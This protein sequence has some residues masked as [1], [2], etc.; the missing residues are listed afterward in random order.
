VFAQHI[1]RTNTTFKINTEPMTMAQAQDWCTTDGG[2]LVSYYT[3]EEQVRGLP[4]PHG[5][6][7]GRQLGMLQHLRGSAAQYHV[8]MCLG[9]MLKCHA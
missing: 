1:A 8:C 6:A 7:V 3:A 9:H 2:W 4:V 5:A